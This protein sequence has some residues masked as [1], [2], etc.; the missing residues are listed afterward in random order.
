MSVEEI[1]H[2]STRIMWKDGTISW[3]AEDVLRK[4]NPCNLIPYIIKIK[5]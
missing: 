4:Q 5:L 2:M 1:S 3:Y